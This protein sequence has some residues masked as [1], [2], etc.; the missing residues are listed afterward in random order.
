MHVV[1]NGWSLFSEKDN[2]CQK[3]TLYTHKLYLVIFC[4][5]YK[6]NFLLRFCVFAEVYD[7]DDDDDYAL[8]I[9]LHARN[10]TQWENF[11]RK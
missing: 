8:C 5:S 4:S 1:Q 11:R 9:A 2:K 3:D 6:F 10:I 7:D